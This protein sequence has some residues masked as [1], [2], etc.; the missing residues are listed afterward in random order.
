MHRN[1]MMFKPLRKWR[2]G[3]DS[4]PNYLASKIVANIRKMAINIECFAHFPSISENWPEVEKAHESEGLLSSIVVKDRRN[5][6][7]RK[8]G[9]LG[10][11]PALKSF[12]T[13][14]RH[15]E[16]IAAGNRSMVE[17]FD[18]YAPT[19]QALGTRRCCQ[20]P[21]HGQSMPGD[22]YLFSPFGPA[23]QICQLAFWPGP[24]KLV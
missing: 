22:H 20:Q 21:V 15:S 10:P 13:P 5:L 14:F 2:R 7:R 4:K 23:K 12:L 6:G 16:N 11:A 9:E 19:S 3:R 17:A 1:P 8:N 24:R 18:R